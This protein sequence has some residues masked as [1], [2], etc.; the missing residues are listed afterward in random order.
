[1]DLKI[2]RA[3]PADAEAYAALMAHPAVLP[4]LLQQPWGDAE[5]WRKRLA[6]LGPPDQGHLVLV[7][8]RAGELV[9]HGGLHIQRE[10]LRRAHAAGLGIGVLPAHQRQG[11]GRALMA[12]LLDWADRWA[13]LLRIELHVWTDNAPAIALYRACGFEIEGTHRAFALRDGVY[14][15]AHS[16]AR[17][18]PN[19]PQL[20]G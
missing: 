5:F 11:V 9:G 12:A 8:E 4:G 16:M 2:R 18:H 17:L 19:P 3:L 10:R 13:G 1:M 20:R 14:V 15:D 6:E 7:A